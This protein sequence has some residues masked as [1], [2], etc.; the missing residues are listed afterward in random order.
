MA[1]DRFRLSAEISDQISGPLAKIRASL[2]SIKP[3]ADMKA[4]REELDKLEAT[5]AKVGKAGRGG[6]AS[7]G[8]D[9]IGGLGINLSAAAGIAAV[10]ASMR[11]LAQN[12]LELRHVSRETGLAANEL[13]ALQKAGE[14]FQIAPDTVIQNTQSFAEKLA[15]LRRGLGDAAGELR[16]K[17]PGIFGQL[18]GSTDNADALDKYLSFLGKIKDPQTQ[19]QYAELLGLGGM[20]RL[21]TDGPEAMAK[22][23][24]E[25]R[26]KVKGEGDFGKAAKEMA[27]SMRDLNDQI[28]RIQKMAAP[29]LFKD[30][31]AF[32]KS[33]A[34]DIENIKRLYDAIGDGWNRMFPGKSQAAPGSSGERDAKVNEVEAKLADAKSRRDYNAKTYDQSEPRIVARQKE[35]ADQIEALTGELKKLRE[36]GASVSPS[37]FGGGGLGGLI[38]N[39]SL[40]GSGFGGF[41]GRGYGG[42]NPNVTGGGSGRGYSGA[43]AAV[44][45]P[46]DSS[47]SSGSGMPQGGSGRSYPGISARD[48]R[49]INPQMAA[50]IRNS[51]ARHGID[52]DIALRIAN[53]EGLRGSIPGVRNTPG[54]KGT[55]FGPFQL[56]YA[57]KIPGLTLGGLGDVY[58][59]E[60]GHHASDPAHWKEQID[61]AMKN[62]RKSGWGAWHGR[63]GARVGL[64]DGIGTYNGPIPS[65]DAS[66][67]PWHD[68]QRSNLPGQMS[69]LRDSEV[70]GPGSMSA[71]GDEGMLARAR[72]AGLGGGSTR[73]DGS[74]G[75]T[76]TFRNAPPGMNVSAKSGGAVEEVKVDRGTSLANGG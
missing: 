29:A 30:M 48:M 34:T 56:H 76:I 19:R 37:S 45:P 33:T 6:S 75:A 73:V 71:P 31:A 13:R 74:I 46:G 49:G 67:V 64:R 62:A 4:L 1:D 8:G 3:T 43:D 53:S 60:T 2:A 17:A 32:A 39:A 59:R 63:I 41:G 61:F 40:G 47:S 54:D 26:D 58:T 23:W 12:S 35:L 51:A 70:A 14:R 11:Q 65:A 20:T 57:S 36:Q 16:Q 44:M 66:D 5:I 38:H 72:R 27:D 18:K 68:R 22:A 25:A 9:I 21:F 10:A 15:L 52:P 7:G 24:Q 55:S 28:E 42:G 50:Y 69:R